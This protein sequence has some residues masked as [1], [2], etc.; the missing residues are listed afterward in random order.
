MSTVKDIRSYLKGH[1]PNEVMLI[2]T[3]DKQWFE[4]MLDTKLTNDEMM[5]IVR[6][7]E[8]AM[9]F[10]SWGDDLMEAAETGLAD[11]R[12]EVNA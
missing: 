6:S 7:C 11:A 1:K 9:G 12:D 10:L 5:S 2:A 8:R 4:E 3:W